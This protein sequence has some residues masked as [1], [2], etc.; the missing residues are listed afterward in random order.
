ME[1]QEQSMPRRFFL[2]TTGK[3]AILGASMGLAGMVGAE[4]G[5]LVESR[6][7]DGSDSKGVQSQRRIVGKMIGAILGGG[8]LGAAIL[9]E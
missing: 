7:R 6:L 8:A 4:A 2:K 5:D 3:G 1:N 9:V